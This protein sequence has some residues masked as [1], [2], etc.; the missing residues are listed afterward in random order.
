MFLS[1]KKRENLSL[2]LKMSLQENDDS[3]LNFTASPLSTRN[4]TPNMALAR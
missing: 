3:D 1:Y 4:E 2:I